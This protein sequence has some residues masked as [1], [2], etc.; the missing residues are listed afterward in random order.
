MSDD[1]V[2][3]YIRK[4]NLYFL[5]YL[6]QA[7]ILSIRIGLIIGAFQFDPYREIITLLPS[8]EI[9]FSGMPCPFVERYVLDQTTIAT[10]Q[11]MAGY[12]QMMNILE[13][14]M[15]RGVETVAKQMVYP[16][17][18][19][20][21]RRQTDIVNDQKIHDAV[22]WPFVLIGRR[23]ECVEKQDRFLFEWR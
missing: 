15:D 5:R 13:K 11:Q 6:A 21:T 19:K 22:Y 20:L 8:A 14:R 12:P 17:P 2:P 7:C 4:A 16:W 18:A 10:N 1:T 23:L 9:G 3:R